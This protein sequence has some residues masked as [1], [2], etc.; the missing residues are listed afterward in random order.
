MRRTM[1]EMQNSE[2]T[3]KTRDGT[4]DG[5]DTAVSIMTGGFGVACSG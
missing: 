2:T 3:A 5:D 4:G 1:A